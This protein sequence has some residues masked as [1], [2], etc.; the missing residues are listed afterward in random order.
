MAECERAYP[1]LDGPAS[2]RFSSLIHTAPMRVGEVVA[3]RY[4]IERE[5][6]HGGMA[7]VY[8]AHDL[9]HAREVALKVVRSEWVTVLGGGRFL[10]EIEIAAQLRHPHIVPLYDSG[11]SDGILYYV[12]PYESG[13]SLREHLRS[14][15]PLAIDDAITIIRDVCDALAYAHAH[16]VV[17]R[18]IKPDNV[19]MS[20]R[21]ALV[22]DFGVAR[23][24]IGGTVTSTGAGVIVGTP[25][26]MSPEQAAADP[27]VDHRADIYAVGIMAYEML[28]GRVPFDGT[29]AQD[30]LTAH[31]TEVPR[32]LG[33][34]RPD[35]PPEL[36]AFVMRCLEKRPPARWQSAEAMVELLD[37]MWGSH[38]GSHA[39]VVP[40]AIESAAARDS[41]LGRRRTGHPARRP[42]RRWVAGAVTTAAVAAA[43]F[44]WRYLSRDKG[45][46]SIANVAP[47]GHVAIGFLPIVVPKDTGR[48]SALA[49]AIPGLLSSELTPIPGLEV[50]P[51]E[52]IAAA[53]RMNWPLDS[54]ALV[55]DVDYFVRTTV[56]MA[57]GDSVLVTLELIESGIR[58]VRVGS[59]RAPLNAPTTTAESLVRSLAEQVRPMLGSRVR[60]RESESQTASEV[61]ARLRQRA[62]Q[63]RLLVRERTA[64]GDLTGASA[65]VDSAAALLIESERADPN[66]LEP[67]LERASLAGTRA[68]LVLLRSGASDLTSV[69]REFD[70]GLAIVDSVLARAP[71]DPVA[72]ATR[73][74][75]RWQRAVNASTD[76]AQMAQGAAGARAD[77]DDAFKL[78]QT[79]ARAAAD[80]S[81]ISFVIDRRYDEAAAFAERAYRLDRFLEESSQIINR[82]AISNLE[83]ERDAAASV[84]CAEG[85]RRYPNNP[86]HR[87]CRLEVMAW[88]DGPVH[89]DTAWATYRDVRRLTAP[90][91]VSAAAVY[92]Y[93]MAA[94]LARSHGVPADSTRSVLARVRAEVDASNASPSLRDELLAYQA[95]VLYRLEDVV[96]ADALVARLRERNPSRANVLAEHRLLRSYVRPN[97]GRSER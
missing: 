62:W 61:A 50:R 63:Q 18:D 10:R 78:D 6:G 27:R 82:L 66:W 44:G 4:R 33:E 72:L 28:A 47:A 9:K 39:R 14:D 19:L 17:H 30:V 48:L 56:S 12:M 11:D 91:N 92:G 70:A 73:G 88:G 34:H 65:A 20:G 55:R 60:E 29:S 32:L 68:L 16:G 84:W 83:L 81:H 79:L 43:A 36:E 94:V 46:P 57:G 37:E 95:A 97:R 75:L 40:A 24:A 67:R 15:G 3:D 64:R 80:L 23:A 42:R 26:Y 76:S 45:S 54:V 1:L 13:Q 71:R 93:A 25:A 22:S 96:A 69:A 86:A 52:T 21:H 38:T 5:I 2:D 41:T 58:S 8:L 7:T 77:L 49:Q 31:L 85:I 90:R 51:N 87:A 74:R 53:L 35:T 89:P 59:V